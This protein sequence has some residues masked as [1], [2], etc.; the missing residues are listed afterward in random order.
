MA[1]WGD[2]EINSQPLRGKVIRL[3]QQALRGPQSAV[4]KD[5]LFAPSVGAELREREVC[6]DEVL[7][8]SEQVM[9]L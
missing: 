6:L 3:H 5:D 4:C 8:D 2:S 7:G 9:A 1:A